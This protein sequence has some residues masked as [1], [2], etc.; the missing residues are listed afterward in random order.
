MHFSQPFYSVFSLHRKTFSHTQLSCAEKVAK[1]QKQLAKLQRHKLTHR[2]SRG[3]WDSHCHQTLLRHHLIEGHSLKHLD[4]DDWMHIDLKEGWCHHQPTATLMPE[5]LCLSGVS[6]HVRR[7]NHEQI[8]CLL[9]PPQSLHRS[10][11]QNFWKKK[12]KTNYW[13][14][15]KVSLI[16][17]LYLSLSTEC[18]A[19]K[20]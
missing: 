4:Y 16:F 9:C 15:F 6:C 1:F 12:R 10:W 18:I 7:K 11:R 17:Y 14:V 5:S 20:L 3:Q 13:Y 2:V 19:M 8:S